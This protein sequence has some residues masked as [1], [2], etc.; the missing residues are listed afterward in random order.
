M[1]SKESVVGVAPVVSAGG[2]LAVGEG[3]IVGERVVVKVRVGVGEGVAVEVEASVLTNGVSVR[4]GAGV[5]AADGGGVA[6]VQVVNSS[7]VKRKVI[8]KTGCQFM[9]YSLPDIKGQDNLLN[10]NSVF[11]DN[12][13]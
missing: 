13:I 12:M 4:I 2:G 3:M 11:F 9:C 6:G 7:N 8:R 5:V 1:T 10:S